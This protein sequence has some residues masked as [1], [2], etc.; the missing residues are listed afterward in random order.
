VRTPTARFP[1]R[2]GMDDAEGKSTRQRSAH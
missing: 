2:G 1:K